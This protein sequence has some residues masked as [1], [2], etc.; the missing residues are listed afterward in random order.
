MLPGDKFTIG[1]MRRHARRIRAP[2]EHDR[3]HEQS[4]DEQA[5]GVYKPLQHEQPRL[6][7]TSSRRM[8]GLI[9]QLSTNNS[10]HENV[11]L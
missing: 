8:L 3:H 6:R 9:A 11:N 1:R 7:G 10:V 5:F 4:D 2:N